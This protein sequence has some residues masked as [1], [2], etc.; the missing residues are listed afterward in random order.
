MILL[1]LFLCQS[2][3]LAALLSNS[4]VEIEGRAAYVVTKVKI[5]DMNGL[6]LVIVQ[7]YRGN[8]ASSMKETRIVPIASIQSISLHV[9]ESA[10]H[11]RNTYLIITYRPRG[12][13]P[14]AFRDTA[15]SD[16]DPVT[17][18]QLGIYRPEDARAA[19]TELNRLRG[20]Q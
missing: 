20:Q 1:L 3:D 19:L 7:N 17:A 9:D 2:P 16:R 14:Y 18:V 10:T 4:T 5:R 12:E 8:Q 13:G 15:A 11:E 6:T